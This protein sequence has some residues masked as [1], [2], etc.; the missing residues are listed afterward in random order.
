MSNGSFEDLLSDVLD[1]GEKRTDRTGTGTRSL[2]A[3]HQ[4]SYYLADHRVPLITSKRVPWKM[5][6][7]EFL[8]MLSGST[9]I[10][11]LPHLG[12]QTIWAN[13]A[14]ERGNIGPTYGAQY[15][16]A[17]GSVVAWDRE[18]SG[19]WNAGT[20]QLAE[21]IDRLQKT[22]DTRRAVISLWSAPELESMALEPCMV[23]FQFSLRGPKYDKLHLH[24]YQRSA[25]MMLGVPFDLYQGGLLAHLVARELTYR[26][27]HAIR[28]ERLTW[29]AGD[30]HVYENQ[31][32]PAQLQLAQ[33]QDAEPMRATV[34]ID[35]RRE[36]NLLDSTLKPEHIL[37]SNYIPMP[38]I[39]APIAV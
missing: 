23:L 9:N 39:Q 14:D 31:V 25:D 7:A 20:D 27:G 5:A 11:D 24:I 21:V 18:K 17:G 3:P 26:T 38:A 30:V 34:Y 13:W 6:T 4:L 10:E 35:P 16:N 19:L 29:S 22:P 36:F 12:M 32:R 15:R 37:V 1:F 28:A 33:W 8:W 2:F